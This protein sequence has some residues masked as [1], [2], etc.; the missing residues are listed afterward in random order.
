MNKLLVSIMTVALSIVFVSSAS[1]GIRDPRI[2]A[3][4][5]RQHER[6]AEGR[7]SGE[8]THA[9]SKDLHGDERNIRQEERADKSD[10]KFT[11]A[12][13]QDVRQDQS[14][15]SKEIYQDKHNDEVRPAN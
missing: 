7:R 6:I 1:A 8:L 13:R 9:E 12:E 2:N 11:K 4:Q 10:G 15:M 14:A 3:H 5:A